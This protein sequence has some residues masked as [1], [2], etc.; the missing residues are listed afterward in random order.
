MATVH[1]LPEILQQ[2]SSGGASSSSPEHSS[3]EEPG[4]ERTPAVAVRHSGFSVGELLALLGGMFL[5]VLV[6]YLFVHAH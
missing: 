4:G 6:T 1:V 2:K 5:P 3:L